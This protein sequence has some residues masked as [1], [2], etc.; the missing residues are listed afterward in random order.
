MTNLLE[1][2]FGKKRTEEQKTAEIEEV[3]NQLAYKWS[4]PQ[5]TIRSI[6]LTWLTFQKEYM[7]S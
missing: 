6:I 2:V 4:I 3:T 1:K 7:R 5:S